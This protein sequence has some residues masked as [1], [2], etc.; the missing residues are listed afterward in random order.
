M[1]YDHFEIRYM[2]LDKIDPRRRY[3]HGTRP[4]VT[5]K[6]AQDKVR[7]MFPPREPTE[8]EKKHLLIA[9]VIEIGIRKVFSLHT[10]H[11]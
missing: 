5:G 1:E 6:E 2:N 3:H 4:G 9:A 8:M 7:W 11:L 10:C